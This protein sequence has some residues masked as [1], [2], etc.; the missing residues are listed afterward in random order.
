MVTLVGR[1]W[2][3]RGCPADGE[4]ESLKVAGSWRFVLRPAGPVQNSSEHR[5]TEEGSIMVYMRPWL[6]QPPYSGPAGPKRKV[7]HL[8]RLGQLLMIGA[9]VALVGFFAALIT[10]IVTG[11]GG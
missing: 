5:R 4:Q 11:G 8:A 6:D 10:T 3:V 7:P 1:L 2:A 9:A